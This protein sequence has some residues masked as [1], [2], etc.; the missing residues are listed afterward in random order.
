MHIAIIYTRV[1]EPYT[2]APP[3]PPPGFFLSFSFDLHPFRFL[4]YLCLPF[5]CFSPLL[6]LVSFLCCV[7]EWKGVVVV[8][9]RSS[10]RS[11]VLR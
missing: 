5:F 2:R 3:S 7:V 6:S 1:N 8:R 9:S 10:V 11:F 4:M